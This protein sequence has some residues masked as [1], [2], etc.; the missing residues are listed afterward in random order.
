MPARLVKHMAAQAVPVLV[1]EY[2]LRPHN[3]VAHLHNPDAADQARQRLRW[4]RGS[5]GGANRSWALRSSSSSSTSP[6]VY[7]ACP[8][9]CHSSGSAS[10]AKHAG[11]AP[12]VQCGELV[13]PLSSRLGLLGRASLVEML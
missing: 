3:R 9:S 5:G 8:G 2:I 12:L 4:G 13:L 1:S 6:E 11:L 10:Q 7:C